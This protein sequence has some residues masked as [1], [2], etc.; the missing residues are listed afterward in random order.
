LII[1]LKDKRGLSEEKYPTYEA[2]LDL[3]DVRVEDALNAI[4]EVCRKLSF[5]E[6][7]NYLEASRRGPSVI[8]FICG[9]E[10]VLVAILENE[11]KVRLS[12]TVPKDKYRR[13]IDELKNAL[14]SS[15]ADKIKIH[16]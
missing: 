16:L 9:D 11:R 6:R 7:L 4:R 15:I 5:E 8:E 2:E 3:E 10:R 1:H 13:L 12:F 14:N